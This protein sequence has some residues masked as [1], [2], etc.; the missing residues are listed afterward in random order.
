VLRIRR[1]PVGLQGKYSLD[2]YPATEPGL[3]ALTLRTA[4]GM[5]GDDLGKRVHAIV[6]LDGE[7]PEDRA[8]A[9]L[10]AFLADRL[11][12][13][14]TPRTCEWVGHPLRSDAG[15]MRLGQLTAERTTG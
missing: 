7:L 2:S 11:V 1:S 6:Q 10:R 3:A 15:K 14:K 8:E 5:P 13:P 9:E 12:R 4:I